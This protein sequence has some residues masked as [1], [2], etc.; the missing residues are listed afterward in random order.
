MEVKGQPQDDEGPDNGEGVG[1]WE[2]VGV[3]ER[4]KR[5]CGRERCRME[6]INTRGSNW[7]AEGNVQMD[8]KKNRA[9]GGV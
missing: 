8:G 1:G 2:D 9:C 4:K 6:E 5:Y 7:Q 3:R